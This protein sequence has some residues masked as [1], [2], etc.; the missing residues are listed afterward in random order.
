MSALSSQSLRTPKVWLVT[1]LCHP[2]SID[3]ANRTAYDFCCKVFKIRAERRGRIWLDEATGSVCPQSSQSLAEPSGVD[4]AP[5]STWH[6]GNPTEGPPEKVKAAL[7]L[8]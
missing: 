2:K 4:V 8:V 7:F 5:A 6:T 3:L 1:S